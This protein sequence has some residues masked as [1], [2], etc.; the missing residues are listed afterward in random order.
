MIENLFVDESN[1]NQFTWFSY[2]LLLI[3]FLLG[4]CNV[5]YP[6]ILKYLVLLSL[7]IFKKKQINFIYSV[8]KHWKYA[9]GKM[10]RFLSKVT[11]WE[12]NGGK[13]LKLDSFTTATFAKLSQ[14]SAW[15]K[16]HV[17]FKKA[18]VVELKLKF[19]YLKSRFS[20]KWISIIALHYVFSFYSFQMK[21]EYLS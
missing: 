11:N 9:N 6:L 12:T 1:T 2:H 3:K 8:D 14:T 19:D 18:K 17:N 7:Y 16:R 5:G 15:N 21:L 20:L 13:V 10:I 4:I